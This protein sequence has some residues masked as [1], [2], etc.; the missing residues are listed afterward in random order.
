[1]IGYV[2]LGVSDMEKA[3][4]FYTDLLSEFDAKVLMDMGRIAFIG[5]DMKAPMLAVCEPHDGKGCAP[6]NGSMVAFN[7]GSKEAVDAHYKKAIS[8]GATDEGEPGQ[9]IK[10]KFYGAYVRDADSNKI[11]FFYFG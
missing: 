6:G 8:L 7:A 11:A 2:T 5:K 3:K 4:K 1:M 10:D 9:R